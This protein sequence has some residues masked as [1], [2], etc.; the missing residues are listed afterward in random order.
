MNLTDIPHGSRVFVDANIFIYYFARRGPVEACKQFLSRV[1]GGE[2]RAYT[3]ALVVAEVIHRLMVIEAHERLQL[4]PRKT[5]SYLKSH[6]AA[7]QRLKQH[8]ATTIAFEQLGI[9]VLDVTYRDLLESEQIRRRYG[10]L[11]N[12]SLL[13]AVMHR[14][15]ISDLATADTDF[16]RLP[17]LRLW[18]P[19][20]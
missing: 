12:D 2:L 16:A 19:A 18:T 11:T 6:P 17:G 8:L 3:S 4:P 10:L 15:K 1:A 14:Y 5:V 7:V 20:F 9:S 13:V